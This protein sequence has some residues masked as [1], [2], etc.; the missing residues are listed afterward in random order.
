METMVVM[1]D[2]PRLPGRCMYQR[3]SAG[4]FGT[5]L[6]GLLWVLVFCA[7]LFPGRAATNAQ[8][9]WVYFNARGDLAYKTLPK[10]DRIMDFSSAGYMGGGVALPAAPVEF[11]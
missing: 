3:A 11:T 4:W 2:R 7:W 9:Q 6:L 1:R 5:R 10:G 8:S